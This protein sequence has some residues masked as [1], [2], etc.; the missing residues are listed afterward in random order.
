MKCIKKGTDIQRVSDNKSAELVKAG[1]AYCPKK[2]W[3]VLRDANKKKAPKTK[4]P[5]KADPKAAKD[6]K[7]PK[8]SKYR[9]KSKQR[10]S[11]ED[12]QARS[13]EYRTKKYNQKNG[14]E[15][16]ESVVIEAPKTRKPTVNEIL[17]EM[18]KK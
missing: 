2:E 5:E 16:Y 1:W 12:R 17:D 18:E 13:K 9:K 11:S 7:D 3:K 15:E 10:E 6:S 4:A 14:I 8:E